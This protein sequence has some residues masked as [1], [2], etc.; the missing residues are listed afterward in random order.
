[1]YQ[2]LYQSLNQRWSPFALGC[3]RVRCFL[4]SHPC[5]CAAI[6]W[7]TAD[8]DGHKKTACNCPLVKVFPKYTTPALRKDREHVQTVL[9]LSPFT[10][11]ILL[12]TNFRCVNK[13]YLNSLIICNVTRKIVVFIHLAQLSFH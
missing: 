2:M 11:T 13:I 4:P 9:I 6:V 1:M 10:A 3:N 7:S 8:V 12:Y 5:K